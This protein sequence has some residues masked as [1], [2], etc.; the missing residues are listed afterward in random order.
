MPKI[1]LNTGSARYGMSGNCGIGLISAGLH[2]GDGATG[3]IGD[4]VGASIPN[5]SAKA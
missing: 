2:E 5:H 3:R 1:Y 4:R